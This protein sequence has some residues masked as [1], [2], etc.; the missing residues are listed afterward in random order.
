[1]PRK[2]T[3]SE[4]TVSN[5]TATKAKSTKKETKPKDV[6]SKP[7]VEK[8]PRK[9]CTPKKATPEP[10]TNGNT[11][12]L[13]LKKVWIS[14]TQEITKLRNAMIELEEKRDVITNILS[15]LMESEEPKAKPTTV[16][17]SRKTSVKAAPK[18]ALPIVEQ[19]ED[20]LSGINTSDS[21]SSS[22][23]SESEE[24]ISEV[25]LSESSNS[26]S[27]SSDEEN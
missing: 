5:T 17:K 10:T 26:L 7:V 13:E 4:K 12:L 1:M 24:D 3:T 19:S 25:S 14:K 11:E 8:K 16:K 20:E 18:K 23:E 6:V 9:P 27:E 2:S 15:K 21:E 22:S